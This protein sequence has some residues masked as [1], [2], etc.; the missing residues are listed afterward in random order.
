MHCVHC[1]KCGKLIEYLDCTVYSSVC[2]YYQL[3][4]YHNIY[5]STTTWESWTS[6]KQVTCSW[7]ASNPC[8]Y[9]HHSQQPGHRGPAQS[10]S[11]QAHC[12]LLLSRTTSIKKGR[13]Y[14]VCMCACMH[15][16]YN[17]VYVCVCTWK[18]LWEASMAT[19]MGPT[20]ATASCSAF[21]S[22]LLT[23]V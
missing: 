21:S 19:E 7:Q 12:T 5:F 8:Y 1:R 2:N 15:A 3:L 22:S 11:S 16:M 9:R 4:W 17:H 14:Q 18:E 6:N 23:S 13:N 20:V 10:E